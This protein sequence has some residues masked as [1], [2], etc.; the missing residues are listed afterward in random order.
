MDRYVFHPA[1]GVGAAALFTGHAAV[2]V[3]PA[4]LIGLPT[5]LLLF[6]GGIG[7]I[8]WAVRYL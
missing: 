8:L 5:P 6:V 2:Y 1:V 7:A 4:S 3:L